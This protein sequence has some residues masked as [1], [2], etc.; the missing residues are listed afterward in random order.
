MENKCCPVCEGSS[1]TSVL[2]LER[3]PVAINAQTRPEDATRVAKGDINLV[4]CESCGHLFNAVFD[5]SKFGYDESYENSLH[6]SAH[7]RE[8]ARGLAERLVADHELAGAMVAEAGAGPGHFLAMLCDAGVGEAYGFDPSYDPGR[9]DAK[10][11]KSVK[12]TQGL[13]PADGSLRAKLAFSQ[14]VLEHLSSPVTLLRELA[15]SV[16]AT[17]GGVVYSEVP[18]GKTM[19]NRCALWDLIYEHFSYFTPTSLAYAAQ[20]AGLSCIRIS[21][22][23]DGQFLAL[24]SSVCDPSDKLPASAEV[25]AVVSKASQFGVDAKRSIERAR[26]K[27]E[28][29]RSVG[30]VALWGAGSK[31]M[32]YMNLVAQDGLVDAVVDVNPRKDG[33]GIP[34]VDGVIR[35]PESLK[36]IKPATVLIANPVYAS[37]IGRSLSGLNVSADVQP[38][39]H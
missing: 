21:E 30:P 16:A 14:H 37:E 35:S 31:G 5:S 10:K 20:R 36:S 38:L 28:Q 13:F 19:L 12:L 26:Q 15:A 6:Y 9:L 22:Y 34:G 33:Y 39:W 1:L 2:K 8:F 27:L 17:D 29:Y 3:L 25:D 11:H 32:T 7:F 24:D 18:N 23:Y 4:V